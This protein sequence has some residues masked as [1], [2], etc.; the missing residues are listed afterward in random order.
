MTT[1]ITQFDADQLILQIDGLVE[2]LRDSVDGG[3]SVGFLPPLDPGDARS[4]WQDVAADLWKGTRVLLVARDEVR[5]IGSIQLELPSKPN[6]RHRAEVQKLLVHS[7]VRRQGIGT[8][9]LTAAEDTAR[10]IGRSLLVLDTQQGSAAEGLYA[11]YGYSRA[12]EIPFYA[13]IGDGSLITTVLFYRMLE[14]RE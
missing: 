8:Q 14:D 1:S 9:L 11:G 6:A 4:Y 7:E 3:A 13:Q 5:V 10:R 12:G 2:L